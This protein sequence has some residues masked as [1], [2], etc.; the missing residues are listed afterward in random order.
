MKKASEISLRDPFVLLEG[1]TY[2]LYGTTPH[3]PH[4]LC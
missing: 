4:F 3:N 1:G 2:Y